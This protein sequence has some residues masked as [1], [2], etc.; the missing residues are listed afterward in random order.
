MDAY[1]SG[2]A[3]PR[4]LLDSGR[5]LVFE[6]AGALQALFGT[7]ASTRRAIADIERDAGVALSIRGGEVTL[8]G[9][10]EAC[11]RVEAA[12]RDIYRLGQ[13]G[14]PIRPEDI[15]R[16]LAVATK[17]PEGGLEACFGDV[18]ATRRGGRP[19]TPRS[20]AQKRY[21]EAIRQ[22][23]LTFG[24]GPAGTGKTYLA[25]CMAARRL[26][27]R[28]VRRIILTRPAIEA[29]ENLGFLPGTFEDKVSPYMRPIYDSLFDLIDPPKVHRMVEQG[30]IEIAPLAYMRGRTLSEAFVI[31]DE[32]QNTTPQQMKMFLTRL[33]ERTTAVVTGDPSQVDLPRGQRSGLVD[34]LDILSGVQTV[35]VQRFTAGD[36]MRHPLVE[37]IIR[38]YD[39]AA[40]RRAT[41]TREGG[42]STSAAATRG[43]EDDARGSAGA[44]S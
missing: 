13:Q 15:G 24:V 19:V 31:L 28:D 41:R 1:H 8:K 10:A 20:L 5:K 12:L 34:A 37:D 9:D 18:L 6:A 42:A 4:H 22:G 17:V 23:A 44:D 33:G 25:V 29:G 40:R 11:A 35:S 32:A 39:A 2:Q 7:P 43:E 14:R 30:I 16:A 36:V 21:V 27:D 26:L 3:R 38:A